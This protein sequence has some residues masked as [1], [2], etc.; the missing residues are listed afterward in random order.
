M[1]LVSAAAS[2]ALFL[3]DHKEKLA[4]SEIAGNIAD[5]NTGSLQG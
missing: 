3:D 2:E 1:E 5:Y 4:N